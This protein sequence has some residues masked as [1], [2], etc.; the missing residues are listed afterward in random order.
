[1]QTLSARA[2][3]MTGVA[4]SPDGTRVMTRSETR[5]MDVWD[6]GPTGGAEVANVAGAT[7]LVSF[8]SDGRHVTT[9]GRDGSLSIL[10]LETGEQV[11]R[12]NRWFELPRG[13]YSGYEFSYDF[14]PDGRSVAIYSY[15]RGKHTLRDVETGAELLTWRTA[16]TVSTGARMAGSRP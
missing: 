13:P 5:V 1:M 7:E 12:P 14:S 3:E 11:H 4:F 6:V 9:S 10:D 2:G 8:L 16:H 15:T